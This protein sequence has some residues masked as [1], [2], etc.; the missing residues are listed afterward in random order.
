MEFIIIHVRVYCKPSQI[1]VGEPWTLP[2][3]RI[4]GKAEPT[5]QNALLGAAQ[6]E[7]DRVSIALISPPVGI[8]PHD[9]TAKSRALY[10]PS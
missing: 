4:F 9:Q 1:F 7:F 2:T 8:E 10:Q 6:D 5:F 3:Q